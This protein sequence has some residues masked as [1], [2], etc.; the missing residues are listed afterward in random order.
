MQFKGTRRFP[1]QIFKVGF[2][3]SFDDRLIGGNKTLEKN[4][5]EE[6][7]ESIH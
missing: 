7:C 1:A 6:I 2:V 4:N 5:A 3:G